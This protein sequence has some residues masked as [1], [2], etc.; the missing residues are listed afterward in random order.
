MNEVCCSVCSSPS[1][2]HA[3]HHPHTHTLA[4]CVR[5]HKLLHPLI[6]PA[7]CPVSL[8]ASLAIPSFS[9]PSLIRVYPAPPPLSLPAATNHRKAE[10]TGGGIRKKRERENGKKGGGISGGLSFFFSDKRPV[11][12][13][14]R[15]I[16]WHRTTDR[17]ASWLDQHRRKVAEEQQHQ[18]PPQPWQL[19]QQLLRWKQK[20]IYR[21][22][23]S[24]RKQ[25]PPTCNIKGSNYNNKS[26]QQQ[27]N[28]VSW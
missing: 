14:L 24:E 6:Y 27:E 22:D 11:G 19:W 16:C 17:V 9:S 4:Q 26:I 1:V 3:C 23:V 28:H 7:M 13:H 5:S 18:Q 2:V 20:H 8:H 12:I 25:R 10:R 21:E 15:P